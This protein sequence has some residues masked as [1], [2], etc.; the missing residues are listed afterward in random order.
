MK[1]RRLFVVVSLLI[2]AAS[3]LRGQSTT[4]GWVEDF[5][6]R[7]QPVPTA[8]A[9]TQPVS[10][11][12]T[13][14]LQ[15]GTMAVSLQDVINLMLDYNLDIETDRFGPRSSYLQSLVFYRALLPSIRFSGT[16]SRD[17]TFSTRQTDGAD[18]LSQLRHNFAVNFSQALAYGTSLAVDVTMNRSSSNS[19][20]NTFNP[21]YTGNIRYTVG[22]KLLRDRGS[23]ANTRQIRQAE[24]NQKI[25]ET[26]FEIQ[27]SNLLTQAQKAYWDLVFAAEDLKVKQRSFELA[28]RTLEENKTKVEIGTMAPIDV[29]Q[30]QAEVAT[31]RGDIVTSTF[32]LTQTEDQIKKLI[33]GDKDPSLFLVRLA[34]MESPPRPDAVTIPTLEEAV[35]IALENRPEMRQAALELQNREIDVKYTA[36]Q[37]LPIFDV[38]ASYS[39]SGTGGTRTERGSAFGG[40][41][42]NVIPGGI[43]DAFKQLF[44]YDYTGM[45][46]GFSLTIPLN[47]RAAK[48]DY[49]RALTEKQSSETALQATKQ[50]IMLE[51]RNALTQL[52][53]ARARI[54]TTLLTRQYAQERMKAE[55][56]KFELGTSTL[57][58]VL[59]EQR[60]VAQAESSEVQALVN[61]T[62]ALVDLDKAMGL[63]LRKSN[64]EIEKALRPLP[65]ASK[66]TSRLGAN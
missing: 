23:L 59:E 21:S 60:N 42:V 17:K 3:P 8:A 57:R 25:S 44:G 32:S 40:D 56:T 28:E 5:L 26:Q 50:Q 43:G 13:Q 49:E 2:L 4:S 22:Q 10:A 38:T 36:N 20:V 34:A 12:A 30:T 1:I 7:Y 62:K 16:V 48:A 37:K 63:T 27:V 9:S 18:A 39:Q 55:Q 52:E 29:V 66:S 64:I 24:N 61:F 65:V 51:V 47:N 31:R 45:S 46:L 35:T 53:A 33:S 14:G 11:A 6:R 15:T 19:F 58:F 54:E 41:V